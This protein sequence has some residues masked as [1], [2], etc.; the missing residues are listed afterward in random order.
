MAEANKDKINVIR[1]ECGNVSAHFYDPQTMT[2]ALLLWIPQHFLGRPVMSLLMSSP[3]PM[4][5][6]EI[7]ELSAVLLKDPEARQGLT[8]ANRR[9]FPWAT[10][11]SAARAV[12]APELA[13]LHDFMLADEA[14]IDLVVE[15]SASGLLEFPPWAS[16]PREFKARWKELRIAHGYLLNEIVA[17][18]P[19]PA[20]ELAAET[21]LDPV[22][23]RNLLEQARQRE[24]L[25]RPSKG[26]TELLPLAFERSEQINE[27]VR[28]A[29]Q[30]EKSLNQREGRSDA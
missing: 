18:K 30:V 7:R 13:L 24:F 2:E 16:T 5:P 9:A 25:S 27:L 11:V 21:G 3:A 8:A 12:M 1:D 10:M 6:E 29:R 26:V 4:E 22:Q 28:Q 14:G 17:R 15:M 23:I 20:R 19:H